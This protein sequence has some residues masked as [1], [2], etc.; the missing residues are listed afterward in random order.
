MMSESGADCARSAAAS[1]TAGGT[2][3]LS[4][5]REAGQP[6]IPNQG[7]IGAVFEA[8]FA[9]P[10]NL[11]C[12][13]TI[14]FTCSSLRSRI[15]FGRQNQTSEILPRIYRK[16]LTMHELDG[17][18][19]SHLLSLPAVA[20]ERFRELSATAVSSNAKSARATLAMC[21]H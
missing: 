8:G 6:L 13:D 1:F 3:T 19:G 18:I 20:G 4:V 5:S 11:E 14:L 15:Q 17:C 9:A 10:A 21:E 7:K 12:L 2:E 16:R